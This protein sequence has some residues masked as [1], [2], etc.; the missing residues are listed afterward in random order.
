M[1]QRWLKLP[2]YTD[3]EGWEKILGDSKLEFVKEGEK[4]LS[5]Q[6]KLIKATDYLEFSRSGN[7]GILEG[8][9]AANR[10]VLFTLMVAELAEGRGRFIDQIINGVFLFCEMAIDISPWYIMQ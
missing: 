2:Q 5:Y 9:V 4:N 3:R 7:R 1:G 6:W 10:K 8:P